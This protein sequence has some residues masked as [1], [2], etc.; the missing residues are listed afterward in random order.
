MITNELQR[1]APEVLTLARLAG[2][3]VMRVFEPYSAGLIAAR[4]DDKAD[5]SPLTVADLESHNAIVKGLNALVPDLPIV[6]EEDVSSE[7]CR[8]SCDTYWLIDPLDGT[9]EFLAKSDEFTI[10]IALIERGV[11]VWGVV[12][13][14]ALDLLYW[15]GKGLGSFCQNGNVVDRLQVQEPQP[16]C[17]VVSSKSHFNEATREFLD[18][19]GDIE[20]VQAGS[21]LKFCR[22]AEGAADIYPRLGPTCEW[23][24]AAAQAVLEGAGGHVVDLKGCALRYGKPDI[25]NPYFVALSD[26]RLLP[27]D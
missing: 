14:P 16:K 13:A 11:S 3:A 19:L 10:N 21:S 6:S 26:L 1:L 7:F 9:K 18:K 8:T 23:D 24:T 4:L 25:L 27:H 12:Y 20:L 17:R 5:E 15:G 22:V 2:Q